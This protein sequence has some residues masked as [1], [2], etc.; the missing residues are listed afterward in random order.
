MIFKKLKTQKIILPVVKNFRFFN[1]KI[2]LFKRLKTQKIILPVV[3][4]FQVFGFLKI[5]KNH[6]KKCQF[7]DFQNPENPHKVWIF[8]ANG[9]TYKPK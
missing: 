3:K 7:S 5:P 6:Q 9:S 1:I 8:G 4:K 2:S